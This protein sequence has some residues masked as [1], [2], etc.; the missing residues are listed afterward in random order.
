M[1]DITQQQFGQMLTGADIAQRVAQW[2]EPMNA[3][4][5]ACAIDS[6][7]RQAA[8]L[9]QVLVESGELRHKEEALNYSPERL[10]QVWP[11]RFPNADI[12]ARYGHQPQA[13]ANHVYAGR[14]GNGD[15]ASGDGWRYRGRGLIQLT[16][17]DNYASFARASGLDALANPDLLLAP[18]GAARSAA[19]FWQSHGLNEMADR[20]AGG[21]GDAVFVQ[22]TRRINGGTTGLDERKACWKR[23]RHALGLA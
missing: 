13:L 9:A 22:I 11:Q 10:Q 1:S 19:W 3:A 5:R 2:L 4:L 17:R 8:F 15:E 21:D 6:A 23:T 12:A 14:L 16:G 7:Q 20:A 18:E